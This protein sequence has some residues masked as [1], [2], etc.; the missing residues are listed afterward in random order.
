MSTSFLRNPPTLFLPPFFYFLRQVS[1]CSLGCPGTSSVYK[2][3]LKGMHHKCLAPSI[4][5]DC[6]DCVVSQVPHQ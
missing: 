2:A 1:L 6:I 5:H 4:S 3:D